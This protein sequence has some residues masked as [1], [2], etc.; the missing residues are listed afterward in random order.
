VPLDDPAAMEELRRHV[1]AVWDRRVRSSQVRLYGGLW[2]ALLAVAIVAVALFPRQPI[3]WKVAVLL[4]PIV[5]TGILPTFIYRFAAARSRRREKRTRVPR[6]IWQLLQVEGLSR[7]E[8]LGMLGLVAPGDDPA[9]HGIAPATSLHACVACFGSASLAPGACAVCGAPMKALAHSEAL[10]AL[11]GRVRAK[12][13][14]QDLTEYNASHSAQR[15]DPPMLQR[16][17]LADDLDAAALLAE[18][19]LKV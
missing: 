17:F 16:G 18:L 12:W 5:P 14:R 7:S 9:P 4:F 19:G 6:H 1:R 13:W 8:L 3:D 2:L 11:R 10:E 15:R